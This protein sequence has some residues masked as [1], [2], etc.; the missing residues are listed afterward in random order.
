MMI[1]KMEEEVGELEAQV[2]AMIEGWH[3]LC[4]LEPPLALHAPPSLS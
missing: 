3:Q 2:V 1:I 4:F